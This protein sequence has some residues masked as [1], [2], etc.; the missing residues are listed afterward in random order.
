MLGRLLLL[1]LPVPPSHTGRHLC[2][3]CV[4]TTDQ[5]HADLAPV[6]VSLAAVEGDIP[7]ED[8]VRQ[9]LLRCSAERLLGFWRV[10]AGE[11]NLVLLVLGIENRDGVAI[12]D[13]HDSALDGVGRGRQ[14]GQRQ[15]GGQDDAR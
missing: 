9:V 7:I 1:V 2:Q 5:D 13:A 8:Q 14:T 15:Y 4:L 12:A 6:L 10:N 3:I 11:A